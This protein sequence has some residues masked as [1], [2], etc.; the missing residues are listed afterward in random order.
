VF[1]NHHLNHFEK[2]LK[3]IGNG[4]GSYKEKRKILSQYFDLSQ[5][6]YAICLVCKSDAKKHKDPVYKTPRGKR[7]NL[8]KH[9]TIHE[10][11]GDL[12]GDFK[13]NKFVKTNENE[14]QEEDYLDFLSVFSD[15]PDQQ[16]V[17]STSQN[18]ES[19]VENGSSNEQQYSNNNNS[20]NEQRRNHSS[21]MTIPVHYQKMPEAQTF[22]IGQFRME[23]DDLKEWLANFK[24]SLDQNETKP[25]F[26]IKKY[27]T[28]DLLLFWYLFKE[29]Q[30]TKYFEAFEQELLKNFYPKNKRSI[31]R[32]L[33][34]KANSE[35]RALH[36]I[37]E[38]N[39]L[40][41]DE[42]RKLTYYLLEDEEEANKFLAKN[43][44]EISNQKRKLTF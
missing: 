22:L 29:R 33:M 23:S 9:L 2:M 30:T 39:G 4:K 12:I 32:N 13:P 3:Q 28:G 7:D 20:S 34:K 17:Q 8:Y 14:D 37:N 5:D 35:N 21:L 1:I 31:F 40:T 38:F 42:A 19:K 6:L 11:N 26:E 44:L 36:L 24:E 10:K 15:E 18:G 27:L 41:M 16:S 25:F 43:Q